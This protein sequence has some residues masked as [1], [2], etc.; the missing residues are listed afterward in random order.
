MVD[1]TTICPNTFC[2][3]AS[4][5]LTVVLYF[6]AKQISPTT[7]SHFIATV[8]RFFI[9]FAHKNTQNKIMQKL[10]TEKQIKEIDKL[11]TNNHC[12]N[13][14]LLMENAA[15]NV[16]NQILNYIQEKKLDIE[17]IAVFC[18]TGN[19]GG[20]GL[21]VARQLS[22]D[23][24]V[25]VFLVGKTDNLTQ[26]SLINLKIASVIP[27]IT[28]NYIEKIDTINEL[29]LD[30]DCIID[31]LIGVGFRGK[32]R[33]LTA[34]IVEKINATT[35]RK[36]NPNT[37][38]KKYQK[39]L[40]IAIDVPTG[41]DAD[42]GLANADEVETENI[43]KADLTISIL[44][45]KVGMYNIGRNND[46]KTNNICGEIRVANLAIGGVTAVE[47]CNNFLLEK[48]DIANF[49]SKRNPNT[50]KFDYGRVVIIA[51]CE[52]MSGAAA[53]SANAAIKAGAG[54]VQLFSTKIHSSVYPEII[55]ESLSKTDDG[56]I[57]PENFDYLNSKCEKAEAIILGPG[58]GLNA[59]TL[60]MVRKLIFE[61]I[62]IKI[63]IDAEALSVLKLDDYLSK[64]VV[65]TPHFGEF[66]RLINAE[67][68]YSKSEIERNKIE[69]LEQ[70]A[71]RMNCTILL[72]GS[73]T[74]I[75]NGQDFYWNTYGNAGMATAGAGDVLSGIIAAMLMKKNIS[76]FF[77]DQR[78]HS[79]IICNNINQKKFTQRVAIA[80]LIHSLSGDIYAENFDM[81]TL[82]SLDLIN[83]MKFVMNGKGID[84]K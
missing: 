47:N 6:R 71:R 19:N 79:P 24:D 5:F 84:E 23:F 35:V 31:A 28:I 82:T 3:W 68:T 41:F 17:K 57:H 81:E 16:T 66:I 80:S 50:S 65:L 73:T 29:D 22:T 62:T 4:F 55:A 18:G 15:T 37:M 48:S 33:P 54:I 14:L 49:I 13:P 1:K 63:V 45:A 20:D 83:N 30:F 42:K 56:T 40:K 72:K 10:Y 8:S 34:A 59:D 46:F 44:G 9:I 39:I 52:S 74:V 51:G 21:V 2:D 58:I 27:Q 32:L 75:C 60:A 38:Q 76:Y 61:N 36:I 25:N 7:N 12:I 78:R 26:E 77:L 70:T 53:L 69:L 43:F 11:A 67:E 64:N